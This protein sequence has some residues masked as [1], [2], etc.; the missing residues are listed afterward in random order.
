MP[1]TGYDAYGPIPVANLPA[2]AFVGRYVS[3]TAGKCVT[4]TEVALYHSSQHPLILVY[5]DNATDAL[6]GVQVGAEKARVAIPVLESIAWPTSR[7]VHFA[8]DFSIL[9]YQWPTVLACVQAFAKGIG[10][11]EAI[12]GDVNACTWAGQA[13]IR[14]QWQWGQG[15][16][17]GRTIW[18]GQS[19]TLYGQPVD[20]D[21][22]LAPDYGQTPW[23]DLLK[24]NVHVTIGETGQ[25]QAE[26]PGVT[27][28]TYCAAQAVWGVGPKRPIPV[29]T[30]NPTA[31][32]KGEAIVNVTGPVGVTMDIV[33]TYLAS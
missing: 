33:V 5:E 7:P 16:A 8:V 14:Y 26:I 30:L 18:Q 21:T 4:P 23:E 22:A 17:P 15:V 31:S 10:R 29:C 24:T 1:I 25:S 13:P 3:Q 27:P 19:S 32:A 20:P 28:A 9:S 2:G 12:Y 11:P 6:G